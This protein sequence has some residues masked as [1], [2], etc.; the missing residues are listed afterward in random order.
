MVP[1]GKKP[2]APSRASWPPR[3]SWGP[4]SWVRSTRRASGQMPRMTPFMTPTNGS[5]TPKSVV[6]V[7][8]R[9]GMAGE[10]LA[11]PVHHEVRDEDQ[12]LLVVGV[13]EELAV[14]LGGL[15]VGM[16]ALERVLHTLVADDQPADLLDVGRLRPRA[17]E[18][19]L[20]ALALGGLRPGEHGDQGQ[21]A[22]ALPQ[23]GPD[24]LAQA[25]LV[26]HE[27]ERV[28]A[29][30]KRDADVEA[31]AG[32]RFEP[33]GIGAAQHAPDAAA[34]RDERRRLLGDD[35]QVVGLR[36]AAGAAW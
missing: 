35:A 27:V 19:G 5:R 31:V 10:R 12:G 21:R 17:L 4:I 13:G 32:E 24:G 3:M 11:V 15:R 6:S 34:G 30:L 25:R 18:H 33:R 2:T 23:I 29:D 1:G 26:G 22:L 9:P 28:I 8:R 36:G 20:D 7:M 16:G 14:I